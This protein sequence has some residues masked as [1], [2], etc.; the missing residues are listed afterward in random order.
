M[1]MD[2]RGRGYEYFPSKN[3][4][5]QSAEKFGRGKH[6]R[7]VSENFRQRT[8]LWIRK[9]D[10]KIY[11]RNVSCL[12]VPKV[13]KGKNYVLCLRKIPVARKSMD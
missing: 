10:I 4:L 8:R 12:R 5:S 13:S 2:K 1:I 7:C 6:M 3:F 11:R 9:G